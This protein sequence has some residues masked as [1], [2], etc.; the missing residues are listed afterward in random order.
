MQ[1]KHLLTF[2]TGATLAA[3]AMPWAAAQPMQSGPPPDATVLNPGA[4]VPAVPQGNP[5]NRNPARRAPVPANTPLPPPDPRDSST[6]PVESPN[7]FDQRDTVLEP[8]ASPASA[9]R[10][11]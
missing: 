2:A 7:S 1:T 11:P 9:A 5:L 10:R 8:P 6:R 3:L 4:V